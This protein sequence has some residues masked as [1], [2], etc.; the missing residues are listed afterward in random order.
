MELLKVS[1]KSN[2]NMVAGAIAGILRENKEVELQA[3]GAGSVNQAVKAVAVARVFL[4]ED[5]ISIAC[6][7]GFTEI[8]VGEEVRTAIKFTVIRI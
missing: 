2:P 8:S 4:E 3:I 5:A 6:I 7:P 1:A